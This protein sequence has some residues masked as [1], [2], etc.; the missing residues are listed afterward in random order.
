MDLVR[1]DT[2]D[3][4][5]VAIQK[6]VL[7]FT[8]FGSPQILNTFFNN[9]GFELWSAVFKDETYVFVRKVEREYVNNELRLLFREFPDELIESLKNEFDPPF[10]AYNEIFANPQKDNQIEGIDVIVDVAKFVGLEHASIRKHYRQAVKSNDIEIREFKGIPIEDL[11]EF[12]KTWFEQR[13]D[14]PFAADRTHNDAHFFDLYTS[15]Q[16]FGAAAYTQGKLVAYSIGVGFDDGRCIS[17]FNKCLRGNTNLGLQISY[18]KALLAAERGYTLMSL[19]GI[20]ND[21]KKQFLSIATTQKFYGY[22]LFRK[23]EFTTKTENGYTSALF[24]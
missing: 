24:F 14:R 20:N 13:S 5:V 19:G 10:I 23:P 3:K 4:I 22:E 6:T 7:P 21:F 18:H 2:H 1:L 12:W 16:Y 17:A 11:Q 15:D 9:K 8:L